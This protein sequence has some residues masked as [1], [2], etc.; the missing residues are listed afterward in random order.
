MRK[1]IV[2]DFDGV[3][4]SYKSGWKGVNIISDPPVPGM[5][6]VIQNL[7]DNDYEVVVVSTR[8]STESGRAAMEAWF[9]EN[10]FP[11]EIKISAEKPPALVY[12]DD[13]A[14][15]FDGDAS[16]LYSKIINFKTWW[17]R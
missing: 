1:T 8:S 11:S 10:D 15:C 17:Q 4:Q 5:K 2:F 9:V 14:I 12:V 7:I 13:R 6:E 3:I 16:K